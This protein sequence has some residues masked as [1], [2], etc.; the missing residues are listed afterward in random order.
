[1]EGVD[2]GFSISGNG[3][4]RGVTQEYG[5]EVGGERGGLWNLNDPEPVP[6]AISSRTLVERTG[7]NTVE[8]P[9]TTRK[10]WRMGRGRGEICGK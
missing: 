7:E 1:M 8:Q 9:L 5:S 4:E 3:K 2:S 10:A 6:G